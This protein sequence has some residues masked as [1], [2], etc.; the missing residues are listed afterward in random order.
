MFNGMRLLKARLITSKDM[1][2][3]ATRCNKY[4]WETN[5]SNVQPQSAAWPMAHG[6]IVAE[7]HLHAG[8]PEQV[9]SSMTKGPTKLSCKRT[10]SW[11]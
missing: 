1:Q 3:D 5:T 8:F 7:K 9:M 6:I 4:L 11:T 2:Q 10:Y